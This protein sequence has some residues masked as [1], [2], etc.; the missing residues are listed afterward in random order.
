MNFKYTFSVITVCYNAGDC[1]TKT[2]NSIKKQDCRDF[3][4]IVVDGLSKDDT[5]AKIKS[6][7]HSFNA[8][9][10]VVSEKDDGLYDAMNKGI[11]IAEGEYLIFIN[12]D[13]E[14]C[15]D[16]LSKVK[17]VINSQN[18]RPDIVYGDSINVYYDGDQQVTKVR[19]SYPQITCKTLRKGMGV[20]HQSIF[21]RKTLFEQIGGFNIEYSIGADW[22]FLIRGVKNEAKMLYIPIPVCVFPTDGVSAGVHNKQRHRI[23]KKNQLYKFFDWYFVK[24]V[25]NMATMIQIFIGKDNF[26]RLRYKVNK[27]RGEL[28]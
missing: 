6:E 24:D 4:Y 19:H 13:D 26:K 8:R 3:E 21:T 11:A 5:V 23:R 28:K 27:I 22:D 16:I 18:E 9:I 25:F 7:E 20:V 12:A 15:P 10:K 1:I 2:I 17:R 14:L